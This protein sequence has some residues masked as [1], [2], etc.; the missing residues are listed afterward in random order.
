MKIMTILQ[1]AILI[2][3]SVF[4]FLYSRPYLKDPRK[5]GFYRFFGWELTLFL[6][7]INL[8]VWFVDPSS[9]NQIS[10][11]ILLMLCIIV[12]V[13]GFLQITR[14]G[15]PSGFFENT[16]T[17]VKTGI[18]QFI[19]HPL[20]TSLT[21]LTWGAALKNPD[22]LSV[23]TG[24]AATVC[25]YFT[26]RVQEEEMIHKLG[27]SYREYIRQTKMFIPFVI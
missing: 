15:K 4:L 18:F 1:L 25:Y 3:G 19:R 24:V 20:Y 5:H 23:S 14:Y 9:P 17:L 21:L 16:T 6:V 26:A 22:L 10:S 12:F 7:V 13:V 11:W 8:P 2:G 27:E